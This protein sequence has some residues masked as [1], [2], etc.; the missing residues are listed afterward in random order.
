MA[1][2]EGKNQQSA[3]QDRRPKAK[4]ERL[5]DAPGEQP[6]EDRNAHHDKSDR[7]Q[8]KKDSHPVL[9]FILNSSCDKRLLMHVLDQRSTR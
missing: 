9:P 5:A 4:S 7:D 3:N 6:G 8:E 2:D 1:P